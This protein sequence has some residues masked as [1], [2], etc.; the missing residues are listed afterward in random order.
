[1]ITAAPALPPSLRV[2]GIR[3]DSV[4]LAWE[5]PEYD[6]GSPVSGYV[7]ERKDV[8]RGGWTTVGTVPTHTR[9][10]T[11]NKLLEGNEYLFRVMA[12]N[13]AGVSRPVETGQSIEV[14]SPHGKHNYTTGFLQAVILISWMF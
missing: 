4:S 13:S 5:E 6:G 10:Y 7:I 8:N 12:E 14:R 9:S 1:M 3:R 2:T 11:I